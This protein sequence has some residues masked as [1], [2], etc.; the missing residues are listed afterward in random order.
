VALETANRSRDA[1]RVLV[2]VVEELADP[3]RLHFVV[4]AL[5]YERAAARCDS[6][7][8]FEQ[9]SS[10]CGTEGVQNGLRRRALAFRTLASG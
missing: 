10:V 7:P 5:Q 3:V 8:A 4:D 9:N 1:E 2:D 6:L